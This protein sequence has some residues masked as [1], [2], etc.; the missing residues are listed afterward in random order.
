[1]SL[2]PDPKARPRPF[3]VISVDDHLIEPADLFDGRMPA[4]LADRAPRVVELDGGNQAWAFEDALYP[5][6]GL[7]AVIGR[8]KNEWSMDPVRFDEMRKGCWDIHARIADMDTA[9]I[10]ASL[11]FPSL[12]AGFAGTMFARA[13]DEELGQACVRAWNDWHH[14][15]WA[16][17]Y[18]ERIIPLQITWLNDPA[19]AARRSATQRGARLQGAE[20]PGEP[21]PHRP[22]VDAHRSLGPV[23]RGV[24]GDRHGDVPPHRFGG[25]VGGNSRRAARAEHHAV[26]RQRHRRHRRL[27]VGAHPAALPAVE[28]GALRRWDRLGADAPRPARLR[29]VALRCRRRG[30]VGR[31]PHAH[32]S[33][34]A[35]LLVLHHRRPVDVG[36]PRAHRRS[37]TSWWRSTTRTPT[38]AGPTPRSSSGNA[39]PGSPMRTSAR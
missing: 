8:P 30:R 39:S 33:G 4:H 25:V 7:N 1:M 9:G 31:R 10:W 23:A 19:V 22:A 18:P 24:R 12:L 28:R 20:L 14:E 5:N 27:A 17:T 38:R 26:P 37:T 3:T 16:G 2:L 11:C 36:R 13:K 15:V 6:I 21:V 35:Q 29:D 32:R 34:A